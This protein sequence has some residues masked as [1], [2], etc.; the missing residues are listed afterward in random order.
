MI[1]RARAISAISKHQRYDGHGVVGL[2]TPPGDG[3]FDDADL[4]LCLTS[5]QR[6][7]NAD[8]FDTRPFLTWVPLN[9][10]N[11]AL[12]KDPPFTLDDCC[13]VLAEL[14]AS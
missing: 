11:P 10:I 14:R 13:R 6:N 7:R 4:T 12:L 1:T 9:E 8:G 3:P 5:C 2:S